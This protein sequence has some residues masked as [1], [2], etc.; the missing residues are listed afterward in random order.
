MYLTSWLTHQ[1]VVKQR[2]LWWLTEGPEHIND[3][4]SKFSNPL[5][6][7][8]NL[9]EEEEKDTLVVTEAYEREAILHEFKRFP[10][11]CVG[12]VHL[13]VVSRET[14]TQCRYFCNQYSLACSCHGTL[15]LIFCVIID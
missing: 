4:F 6:P 11:G 14:S 1:K 2:V 12:P 7:L 3:L 9:P 8:I 5:E 15:E 10:A 13:L